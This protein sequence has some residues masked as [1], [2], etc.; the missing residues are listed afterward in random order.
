MDFNVNQQS[1]ATATEVAIEE[2]LNEKTDK[3]DELK[4]RFHPPEVTLIK[5]L[6]EK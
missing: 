2:V 3:R 4:L 5:I 1:H 6:Y